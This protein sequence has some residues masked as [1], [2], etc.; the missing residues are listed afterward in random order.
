M[1]FHI[2]PRLIVMDIVKIYP[3]AFKRAL[4]AKLDNKMSLMLYFVENSALA[5]LA[6]MISNL[7][8]DIFIPL[9]YQ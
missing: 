3:L 4:L 1:F 6:T 8:S 2:C 7:F 9:Q 5:S